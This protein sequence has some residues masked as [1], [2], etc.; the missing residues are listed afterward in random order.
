MKAIKYVFGICAILIMATMIS[1]DGG[2][3][4]RYV[5]IET[6]H[7]DM[8]VKLYNST[9]K[10]RDNFIKLVKEGFYDGLLFHRIIHGFMIQGGD[11]ESR[12]APPGTQLGQGG[13]GYTIEPEIGAPH[14]KG[15]IAAARLPDEVNPERRSS[16]SQFYIVQ[17]VPVTDAILDKVEQ[18]KGIQYN[19]EQRRLYK[20]IGGYPYLDN[21]YT[22]FGEVVEGMDVI[23]K[24][25]AVPTGRYNRP[26]EDL[27]MVIRID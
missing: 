1:C 2:D 27:E 7:G 17:G 10:H 26:A 4:Q 16:G 21:E 25:A 24:L 9:P 14:L 23:D 5:I 18:E 6:K 8:R 19:E 20:E 22:V 11:P 3:K 15:A 13:P 12:N